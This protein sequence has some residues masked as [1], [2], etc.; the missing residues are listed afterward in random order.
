[1]KS[2]LLKELAGWNFTLVTFAMTQE[3]CQSLNDLVSVLSRRY[4]AED[5]WRIKSDY[6]YCQNESK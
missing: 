2:K 6:E 3:H 5:L 4:T 1:M